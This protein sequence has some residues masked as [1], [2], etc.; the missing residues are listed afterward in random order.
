MTAPRPLTFEAL[1]RR[2]LARDPW[3]WVVAAMLPLTALSW[4][5]LAPEVGVMSVFGVAALLL[6]PAVLA[7]LAPRLARRS[8][9]AFWGSLAPRPA[10][11]YRGA[12]VGSTLG[13]LLPL[14]SG[15]AAAGAVVGAEPLAATAL[16]AA[17]AA[18]V[19]AY[20][21][22]AGL[23]AA[24]TLD[25]ARAIA[26][27]AVV[28]G[29]GVVAYE[30]ALVALAVAF[31]DRVYEPYLVA[32]V[33]AHPLEIAR[34]ALL[35]TLDTPV[36]AGPTGLLLERWWGWAPLGP[37]FWAAVTSLLGAA[38]LTVVAGGILAR[39]SR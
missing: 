33:L 3:V 35:R 5:T 2:E 32:L 1:H 34:V 14:A 12:V 15:A 36:F 22:L 6:P 20:G 7:L 29:L 17:V 30:P 25:P 18:I 28:W 9:W 4:R 26:L 19:V 39:R 37:A 16:V 24:A 8:T 21:A 31:A 10:G 13:A 27:G 38:L 11:A 23:V